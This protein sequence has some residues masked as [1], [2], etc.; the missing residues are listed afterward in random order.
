M[1]RIL[2]ALFLLLPT[3]CLAVPPSE[4]VDTGYRRPLGYQQ[5][6]TAMLQSSVGFTMPTVPAGMSVGYAVVQCNGGTVRWR[7]DGVA[8][9]ATVGMSIASG[10]ELDYVGEMTAIRFISSSSEPTCDVSLYY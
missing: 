1:K 9:T 5:L 3:F 4:Y 8:P 2:I 6:T 7:D 10:A